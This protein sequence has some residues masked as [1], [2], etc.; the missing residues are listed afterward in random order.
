MNIFD[1][2][3][4][5]SLIAL[6]ISVVIGTIIFKLLHKGFH[7]VHLGFGAV[8]GMWCGCCIIGAFIVNV[9]SGILF[10]SLSAIWILIRIGLLITILGGLVR[11][12]FIKVNGNRE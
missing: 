10:W 3:G 8:I 9:F 5:I 2:G 7:I 4:F 11:F 1:L 6:V 12:I